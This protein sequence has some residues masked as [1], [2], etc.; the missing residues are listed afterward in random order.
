[1]KL[2]VNNESREVAGRSLAEVME[3]LGY[4]GAIIATAV[5]GDFA[6]AGRRNAILLK[7]GDQL[8]VLAPMRGG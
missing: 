8:E 2:L 5:N 3:E 7:D 6:P 1:M 4:G